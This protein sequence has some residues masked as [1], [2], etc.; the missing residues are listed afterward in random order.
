M[1][2]DQQGNA[3]SDPTRNARNRIADLNSKLDEHSVASRQRMRMIFGAMAVMAILMS[4]GLTQ[5]STLANALDVDTVAMMGRQQ[6]QDHLPNGRESVQSALEAQAP[7]IVEQA[8]E[9]AIDTLPAARIKLV[10]HLNAHLDSINTEFEQAALVSMEHQIHQA[11]RSIDAAYPDVP[12]P[13]REVLVARAAAND[14]TV[15]FQAALE[16]LYPH[17]SGRM[18]QLTERVEQLATT[19]LDQLSKDDRRQR[20]IIETILQ[21][22]VRAHQGGF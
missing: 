16:E 6:V 7:E 10:E 5:I 20:E 8:L 1:N 18:R 13:Q 19:P 4:F 17:Y 22:A 11:R 15:A 14:V 9:A 12:S 2:T 3:A 21:L